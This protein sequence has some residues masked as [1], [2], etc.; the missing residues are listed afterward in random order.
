MRKKNRQID[1]Y[2]VSALDLFASAMGV[3][4]LIA[5]IA[6]PYYLNTSKVTESKVEELIKE[7]KELKKKVEQLLKDTFCVIKMEWD[8]QKA[9]DVDLY[10]TDYAGNVFFYKKPK[11]KANE[12]ASLTVDAGFPRLALHG[13]EI[14]LSK[15]LKP[16][17][18]TIEY[19]Y[20][21]GVP[22]LEI[23][24]EII[25]KSFIKPLPI[26]KFTE[27]KFGEKYKIKVA[28]LNVDN[29]GNISMENFNNKKGKK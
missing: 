7:N 10:V 2:S 15:K 11:I 1:I 29:K 26:K 19:V 20:A 27:E 23:K 16:G 5:V 3:F 21:Q 28:I 12:D 25:T 13:T 22:P 4:L 24:G 9:Q 14:W 17:K 18:Y 6:L 8:S